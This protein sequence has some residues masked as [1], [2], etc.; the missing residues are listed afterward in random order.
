MIDRFQGDLAV[1][2]EAILA[3]DG[4]RIESIFVQAKSA[5]DRYCE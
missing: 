4:K 5:R 3:N 1:L 2:R